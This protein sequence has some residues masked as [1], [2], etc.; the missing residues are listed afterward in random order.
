MSSKK[1]NRKKRGAKIE[2]LAFDFLKKKKFLAWKPPKVKFQSQDILGYFDLIALN[3][4]ELKLIQVQKER[5]RWYKVK[6][7]FKLP[8]PKNTSY[9]LWIYDSKRKKFDIIKLK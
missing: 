2:K 3:K 5:K 8:K 4:K 7:I 6:N 1:V 9:E